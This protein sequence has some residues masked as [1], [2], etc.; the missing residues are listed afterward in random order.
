MLLAVIRPI[1]EYC[2]TIWHA[3]RP[4]QIKQPR[5]HPKATLSAAWLAAPTTSASTQKHINQHMCILGACSFNSW[6]DQRKLEYFLS[7]AEHVS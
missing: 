5:S 6:A 3:T 1:V 4:Q 2:A 7:V